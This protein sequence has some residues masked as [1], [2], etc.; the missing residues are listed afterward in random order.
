MRRDIAAVMTMTAVVLSGIPT[1][2]QSDPGVSGR[3]TIR[4]FLPTEVRYVTAFQHQGA[5]GIESQAAPGFTW[6]E[7]NHRRTGRAAFAKVYS[8]LDG[9]QGSKV[10]LT[11]RRLTITGRT[12]TVLTRERLTLPPTHANGSTYTATVPMSWRQTWQ[13]TGQGWELAGLEPLPETA[14]GPAPPV[15]YTIT[16]DGHS[17]RT[18]E[19]APNPKTT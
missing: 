18:E 6:R 10:V 2:A 7:G 5:K 8:Y 19:G 15:E 13:F 11:I 1:Q 14:L 16:V 9:F 4:S 17:T 3:D 12:A